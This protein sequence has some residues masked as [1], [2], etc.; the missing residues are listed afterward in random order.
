MHGRS[1]LHYRK[2]PKMFWILQYKGGQFG[3]TA[4]LTVNLRMTSEC[5]IL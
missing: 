2:S 5:F 3:Y 1:Q 4:K